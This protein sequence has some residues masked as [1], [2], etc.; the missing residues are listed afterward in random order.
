MRANLFSWF[1]G[2]DD[3][4]RIFDGASDR[5]PLK[6][7]GKILKAFFPQI[8]GFSALLGFS[9]SCEESRPTPEDY[10]FGRTVTA[11]D[12]SSY[13]HILHDSVHFLD[14]VAKGGEYLKNLDYCDSLSSEQ[15][16]TLKNYFSEKLKKIKRSDDGSLDLTH[17][18]TLKTFLA[19]EK[20]NYYKGDFDNVMFREN[21]WFDEK[22][23]IL[24]C[25]YQDMLQLC[26]TAKKHPQIVEF[27]KTLYN[28]EKRFM[29]SKEMLPRA[30]E[31][32]MQGLP[33]WLEK[34]GQ[35]MENTVYFGAVNF[36]G[37]EHSNMVIYYDK[38]GDDLGA[39]LFIDKEGNCGDDTYAPV[40]ST[41]KHECLHLMQ[42][43]LGQ[44]RPEEFKHLEELG[45]TLHSL[46]TEDAIYKQIKGIP[47][48]QEV[49][50][51]FLNFGKHKISLGKIANDTRELM[52]KAKN[53]DRMDLLMAGP[54]GISLINRWMG[55]SNVQPIRRQQKTYQ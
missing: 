4:I 42:K 16:S 15:K 19:F 1:A 22:N 20:L 55:K 52:Q 46:A 6:I 24:G 25:Y 40:G 43:T 39:D 50:Y 17:P 29:I 14:V 30:N 44:K 45:P 26:E 51:G 49:D 23:D 32:S 47:L 35:T 10:Y 7:R 27:A 38:P 53:P 36:L 21:G 31:I 37:S 13:N 5:Q 28:S 54:D 11:I 3:D 33:E 34:Y 2:D 9:A 48:E 8:V 12:D 18:Q 41:I